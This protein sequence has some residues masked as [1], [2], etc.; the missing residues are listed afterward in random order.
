[1]HVFN[2]LVSSVVFNTVTLVVPFMWI[3]YIIMI[4]LMWAN[5]AT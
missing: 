4:K 5:I 1:M 3:S 2:S